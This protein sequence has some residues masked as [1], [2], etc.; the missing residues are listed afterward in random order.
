MKYRFIIIIIMQHNMHD[1]SQ[2]LPGSAKCPADPHARRRPKRRPLGRE[3]AAAGY[4]AGSYCLT[5]RATTDHGPNLAFV[6]RHGVRPDDA[7][8]HCC[9]TCAKYTNDTKYLTRYDPMCVYKVYLCTTRP[10]GKTYTYTTTHEMAK[11]Y[12]KWG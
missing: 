12:T 2:A 10:S 1:V 8:L 4:F 5:T 9:S 6:Q 3:P 11:M 7:V